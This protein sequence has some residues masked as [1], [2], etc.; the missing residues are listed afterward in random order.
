MDDLFSDLRDEDF[1]DETSPMGDLPETSQMGDLPQTRPL[2]VDDDE[3]D[4]LR[5]KTVRTES[6]YSGMDTSDDEFSG[7]SGFSLS[8]FTTSQKIILLALLMLDIVAVGF[9]FMV[10]L[11]AI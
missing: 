5:Q 1:G 10:L 8:N 11:G 9:G 2:S 6:T 4:M 3:F 7:R